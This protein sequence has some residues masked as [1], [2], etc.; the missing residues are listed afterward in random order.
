VKV[1]NLKKIKVRTYERGVESETY[2]CGTGAT[3]SAIISNL[4]LGL[5]PH[6]DVNT[7]SGEILRIYFD[8][9]RR[10]IRDVYLEGEAKVVYKGGMVYV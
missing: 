2:A 3:A 9:A 5:K 10:K 4:I 7:K 8:A 1:V 6:I